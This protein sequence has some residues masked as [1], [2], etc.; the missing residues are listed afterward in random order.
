MD[1]DNSK[2]EDIIILA[3]MTKRY[4]DLLIEQSDSW[5]SEEDG[6][7]NI[8]KKMSDSKNKR[9]GFFRRQLNRFVQV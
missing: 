3:K 7:R 2:K 8:E 4:C 6:M 9:K 5:L 1:P